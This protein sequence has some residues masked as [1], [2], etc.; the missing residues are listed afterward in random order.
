MAKSKF[1]QHDTIKSLKRKQ[2]EKGNSK[3]RDRI[4]AVIMIAKKWS[5]PEIADALGF[6][7]QWVKKLAIDYTRDGLEGLRD[8]S[9]QG[10]QGFLSP[11]QIM[12]L[13]AIVLEG[14]AQ[15]ELL[16]RYRISDLKEIVKKKWS[17][18]YSTAGLHA[19]LQ[20]MQLSHIT[21]RPQSPKNDPLVM[22]L[23][24]KKP[25]ISSGKKR[26]NTGAS[27][28]G[29]KTNRVLDKKASAIVSGQFKESESRGQ[30]KMV[31]KVPIS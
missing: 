29:F 9:R 14:P 28:S 26:R 3:M 7:L 24:K 8:K 25:K 20:R 15:D 4:R 1:I 10:S 5:Y 30:G 16:S 19:L 12:E 2:K 23:W 27:R 18:V 31:L 11:D 13:Y 17:V 22:E 21:T 6:S